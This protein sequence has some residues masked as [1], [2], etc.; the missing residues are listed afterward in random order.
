MPF[1]TINSTTT[2]ATGV[3]LNALAAVDNT[4]GNQFANTGREMIEIANTNG[5]TL[6]VT[7]ITAGVYTVGTTDYAVADIN[8]TINNAQ[9]K[10]FGPFDTTLF[11]DANNNVQI[12]YS[13]GANVT[14][15]V[16]TLGTN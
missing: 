12:T 8:A 14:Q 7:I 15:R 2:V 9:T 5:P 16:I 10:I 3:V 6:T 4:N 11:N 13:A 1:T